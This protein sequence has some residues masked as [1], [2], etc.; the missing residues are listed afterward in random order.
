LVQAELGA[1]ETTAE[2]EVHQ[3]RCEV[4]VNVTLPSLLFRHLFVL[5]LNYRHH[6]P[7][8]INLDRDPLI[9][10]YYGNLNKEQTGGGI[11]GWVT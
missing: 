11:V 8:P 1:P 5:Y 2:K 6:G 4:D 3:E 7:R 9:F 10:H